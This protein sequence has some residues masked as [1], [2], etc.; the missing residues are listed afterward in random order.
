VRYC[1][2]ATRYDE[3]A[4]TDLGFVRVATIGILPA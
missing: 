4:A 3:R 2:A 1:R